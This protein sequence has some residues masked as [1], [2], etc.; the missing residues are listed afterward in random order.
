MECE[1][2]EN[3]IHKTKSSFRF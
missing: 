2:K 1:L 3:I